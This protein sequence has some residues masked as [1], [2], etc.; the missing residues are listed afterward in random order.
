MQP[1]ALTIVDS[2]TRAVCIVDE[3][4][5]LPEL[6]DEIEVAGIYMDQPAWGQINSGLP[7][8]AVRGSL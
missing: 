5:S 4:A 3:L 8:G 6:V 7:M 1:P 2:V